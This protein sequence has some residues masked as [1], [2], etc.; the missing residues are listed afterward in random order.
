MAVTL[1]C[2]NCRLLFKCWTI[3]NKHCPISCYYMQTQFA[4]KQVLLHWHAKCI[5]WLH[6]KWL[7]QKIVSWWWI[8]TMTFSMTCCGLQWGIKGMK[9]MLSVSLRLSS[10]TGKDRL[11]HLWLW[12]NDSWRR[13]LFVF[14]ID[15]FFQIIIHEN[16]EN[17]VTDILL[18]MIILKKNGLARNCKVIGDMPMLKQHRRHIVGF[19][20]GVFHEKLELTAG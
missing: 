5:E 16:L 20:A 7:F 8:K 11:P 4:L 10:S 17:S 9:I 14:N 19:T 2:H 3:P 12:N 15:S 18:F 13:V 6:H 1:R